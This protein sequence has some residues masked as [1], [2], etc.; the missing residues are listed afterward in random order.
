MNERTSDVIVWRGFPHPDPVMRH[1]PVC[2]QLAPPLWR[3]VLHHLSAQNAAWGDW[4][5]ELAVQT[6]RKALQREL[7]HDAPSGD[8][9]IAIPAA[10]LEAMHATLRVSFWQPLAIWFGT[11]GSKSDG[12]YR[13]ILTNG[14]IAVLRP[15]PAD[16][17]RLNLED[18]FFTRS[19]EAGFPCKERR[20]HMIWKTVQRYA[21]LDPTR[22]EFNFHGTRRLSHSHPIRFVEPRI[23]D[24]LPACDCPASCPTPGQLAE[25]IGFDRLFDHKTRTSFGRASLLPSRSPLEDRGSAGASLSRL[26]SCDALPVLPCHT[27]VS[28]AQELEEQLCCWTQAAIRLHALLEDATDA[29]REELC[30][31]LLENRMSAWARFLAID[32]SF[33]AGMDADGMN[34]DLASGIDAVMAAMECFDEALQAAEVFWSPIAERCELLENCQARLAGPHRLSLPWFMNA[35]PSGARLRTAN[36]RLG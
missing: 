14:A 21:T 8:G 3:R 17:S 6:L 24:D 31:S 34:P 30:L 27:A 35:A 36:Y 11:S 33:A 23:W 12:Y 28:A 4:L 26:V 25:E 13:L 29:Y 9:R 20:G 22:E 10:V 19:Q 2:V 5:G 1:A 15:S 7:A 16:P 18:L 32:E